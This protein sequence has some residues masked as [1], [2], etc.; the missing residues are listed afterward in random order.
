MAQSSLNLLLKWKSIVCIFFANF[1]PLE[2]SFSVGLKSLTGARDGIHKGAK[3]I[4]HPGPYGLLGKILTWILCP[5]EWINCSEVCGSSGHS[6][7]LEEMWNAPAGNDPTGWDHRALSAGTLR[8][9]NFWANYHSEA[10]AKHPATQN[11][12]LQQVL[13]ELPIFSWANGK[14]WWMMALSSWFFFP[15]FSFLLQK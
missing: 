6:C 11:D 4:R 7:P 9:V 1:W 2:Q 5:V 8:R 10:M 13:Q 15:L 14:R 3:P 12:S